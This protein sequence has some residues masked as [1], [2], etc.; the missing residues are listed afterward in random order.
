[1]S[2]FSR[3]VKS[4]ASGAR[5]VGRNVDPTNRRGLTGRGVT[6]ATKVPGGGIIAT[7]ATGGL[8]LTRKDV[9]SAYMR[10]TAI[11]AGI[12]GGVLAGGALSGLKGS[13][14]AA[15]ETSPGGLDAIDAAAGGGSSGGGFG[16]VLSSV[17]DRL[18]SATSRSS[19]TSRGAALDTFTP[20]EEAQLGLDIGTGKTP[21]SGK[22]S[23]TLMLAG[24]LG[25]VVVLVL[26]MLAPR[27]R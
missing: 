7:A 2:L 3:A 9:Q 8:A 25:L 1:M 23:R 12:A 10:D 19:P 11:G 13:T 24:G 15:S 14:P 20:D 26:F 22:G 5:S 18:G 6:L 4:V 16:D 21:T 17:T 27:R